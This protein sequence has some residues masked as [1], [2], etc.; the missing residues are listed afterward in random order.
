MGEDKGAGAAEIAK[1]DRYSWYALGVLVLVC[2]LNFV[3][4]QLLTILAVDIKRDLAITDSEFGFLYGTAFGVF[5][6]LFGIPLGKLAD[7]YARTRLL[8]LG[9]ALWSG[10]TALSGLSR[11]FVQLGAARIGVGVGEATAGPC[12][13]S[14]LSDYFPPR[15]RATAIAIYS[16]GIYLGGGVSL[17][18]GTSIANAWNKAFAGGTAPLGLAGWQAAFIAVGMPGLLLA[19]WVRSLREPIR[20]RFETV[21]PADVAPSEAWK[22]FVRDLGTIVPPFTI[23]AAARR[24]SRALLVNL[25]GMAVAA[26]IGAL[27]TIWLGDVVQWIALGIGGY[28]I[29]SWACSLRHEDRAAFDVIWAS[30]SVVGLNVGYGLISAVSY[31]SSAFGPLY[32]MQSFGISAGKVALVV[33]GSGAAGG[34]LGVIAGGALGDRVAGATQ[35]SRRVLVV[36]IS[37]ILSTIPFA[38]MLVTNSPTVFLLSVFPTWFLL[39]AGLGSASGTMV[40][41]VPS[42]M[43]AT[44]TAAFFLGATVL[45]LALGPYAAGRLSTAFGSLRLGLG[46]MMALFPI[47][48]AVLYMAWK[49]C[50]RRE[51]NAIRA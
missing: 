23:F 16:A 6:A 7:R 35:H 36:I 48:L 41:I 40:N 20:G 1:A 44:A 42:S 10:M 33:G 46:L 37:T 50:L 25:A 30:P 49:D 39:S 28:A 24:G 19:M 27:L 38:A 29:F 3:D 45:G 21:R 31:A 13:Y 34:A 11:S 4:R 12:A 9:L 2:V 32:A 17:F 14:M 51:A 18:I 47:A 8:S 15:R 26:A 22:G 5:Y 43:R